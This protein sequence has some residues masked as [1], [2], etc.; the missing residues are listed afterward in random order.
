MGKTGKKNCGGSE[1]SAASEKGISRHTGYGAATKDTEGRC[2]LP[3]EGLWCVSGSAAVRATGR[4]EVFGKMEK[5]YLLSVD[6]N[7]DM[8]GEGL[9]ERSLFF[10]GSTA[11]T[12]GKSISRLVFSEESRKNR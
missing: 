8:Y 10:G 9:S 11:K 4:L 2:F 3:V 7:W 1:S 12:A 6:S 5:G